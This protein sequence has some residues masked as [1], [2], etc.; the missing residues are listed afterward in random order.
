MLSEVTGVVDDVVS[1]HIVGVLCEST[2]K[3]MKQHH[4]NYHAAEEE[5]T[6]CSKEMGRQ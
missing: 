3:M 2:T 6:G 5:E 4:K 1:L